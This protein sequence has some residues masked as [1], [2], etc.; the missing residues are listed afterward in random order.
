MR[1]VGVTLFLASR[2]FHMQTHVIYPRFW[3]LG[4]WLRNRRLQPGFIFCGGKTHENSLRRPTGKGY[5]RHSL[6]CSLPAAI[7]GHVEKFDCYDECVYQN[8]CLS[9][10]PLRRSNTDGLS[11]ARVRTMKMTVTII[12][13]Y[14]LCLAPYAI[15]VVW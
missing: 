13:T 9:N 7:V 14:F 10:N 15:L 6:D 1:S 5:A 4:Y 8:F 12:T 11:R 3:A 2:G